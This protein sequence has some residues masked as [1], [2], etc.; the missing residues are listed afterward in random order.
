MKRGFYKKADNFDKRSLIM[1]CIFIDIFD[2]GEFFD[3]SIMNNLRSVYQ[4]DVFEAFLQGNPG[5]LRGLTL[6]DR[7]VLIGDKFQDCICYFAYYLIILFLPVQYSIY[8]DI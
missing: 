8:E 1:A 2:I 6:N 7:L 4:I 3:S 5:L